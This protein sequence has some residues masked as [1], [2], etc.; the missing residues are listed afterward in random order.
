[1]EN[2]DK[3]DIATRT[4]LG[5]SEIKTN[6]AVNFVGDEKITKVLTASLRP[7]VTNVVST[8]GT[9]RFEGEMWYDFMV[10]LENGNVVP[11]S[12]PV[13]F[14]GS[15][16]DALVKDGTPVSLDYEV[17]ELSS[18]ASGEYTSSVQFTGYI[19][20]T[21]SDLSCAVP[22]EFVMT[23]DEDIFF[24]SLV[25]DGK[26]EGKVEIELSKDTKTN[27]ILFVR[28]F[29]SI[30]SIVPSN[31]YF[32]VSG[33]IFST[34]VT[35][36]SEGQIRAITKESSFSEEIEAKGVTKE[37]N[38]QA[39]IF[40]NET[41][42]NEI[43]GENKFVLEVPFVINFTA[44]NKNQTKCVCDAYSLTK[45]VNLTTS[46]LV[47]D[48]FATTKF[49]EENLLTN[50]TLSNDILT[51]DKILAVVPLNLQTVNSE[52]RYNETLVEGIAS[53]NIVYNHE[54]D[55]GNMMLSS[56]DVE[57]PFSI[58]FATPDTKENDNVRLAISFGDINVK[59]RHG[60]E[61]EILCELKL[62]YSIASQC[63]SSI[64][65]EITLGEEKQPKDCALEIYVAKESETL[66]DI[67]K[68]LNITIADLL[69]QNGELTLPL[70]NGQ[71]IVAYN[72][73]FQEE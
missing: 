10:V 73:F 8:S 43:D 15:L 64:T 48:E 5:G 11:V 28:S 40:V 63:I 18:T 33:E 4:K 25:A 55:D 34:I 14:E 47:R 6:V 49:S 44:Y 9:V 21:N 7:V 61:L 62:N 30:K 19:V 38:I 31:D 45:E 53:V 42:I 24:D 57:V 69:S 29:A 12:E 65:T 35:E 1:M 22:P 56:V 3:L 66:W 67:A 13:K 46:S 51:I 39:N 50:F 52:I 58:C 59:A 16:D 2:T 17:V 32:A 54:D 72:R 23:R 36:S 20:E 71:K 26:Y 60:K 68:K 37:S 27:K 70:Q 41:T